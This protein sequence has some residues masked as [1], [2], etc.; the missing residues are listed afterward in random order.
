[1]NNWR[2]ISELHEDY[3]NC[4]LIDIEDPGHMKLGSN[5]DIDFDESEWTHFARIPALTTTEAER[6][7]AEVRST[8]TPE[9]EKAECQQ[10]NN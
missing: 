7:L 5:L 9:R 6:M 1:M 8:A 2:P 3:G 4:V 10:N